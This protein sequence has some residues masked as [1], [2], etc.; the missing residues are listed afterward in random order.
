MTDPAL[1]H[2]RGMSLHEI[3]DAS[4]MS[5]EDVRDHLADAG[6]IRPPMID[7]RHLN[8]IADAIEADQPIPDSARSWLIQ[9][10]WK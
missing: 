4:G 1:L 3:A 7:H 6:L 5:P 10:P 8:S 2:K 9:R